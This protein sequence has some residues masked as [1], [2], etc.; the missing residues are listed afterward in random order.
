MDLK[1]IQDEERESMFGSV[2]GVS[3]PGMHHFLYHIIVIIIFFYFKFIIPGS[4][5]PGGKKII[6]I[7][8][9]DEA[10]RRGYK[11]TVDEI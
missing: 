11:L 8:K 7:I 5:D 3:G 10:S 6:I 4:K 2:F 1:K 9:I